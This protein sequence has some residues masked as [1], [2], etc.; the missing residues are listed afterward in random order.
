MDCSNLSIPLQSH[1]E[2]IHQNLKPFQSK[3]CIAA[4][5]QRSVLNVHIKTVHANQ[6]MF[7]HV[8]M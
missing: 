5:G 3:M 2:T 8:W 1:V 4:F 6:K 7:Y